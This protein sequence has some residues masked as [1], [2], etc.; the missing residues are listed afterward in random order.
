MKKTAFYICLILLAAAC[1]KETSNE[2]LVDNNNPVNDTAWTS[3]LKTD[4]PVKQLTNLL[5]PAAATATINAATGGSISFGQGVTVTFPANF[6][7]AGI[8]TDVQVSLSYLKSKGDMIRFGRPTTSNNRILISG[9][10][11]NIT[12]TRNGQAAELAP[13]KKF[14]ISYTNVLATPTMGIFFGDTAVNNPGTVFTDSTWV[15]P[16]DTSNGTVTTYE[17]QDSSGLI[18]GYEILSKKFHFINC[19]QFADSSQARGKVSVILPANFTNNNTAVF[20]V[21][22]NQLSVVS[23]YADISNHLF[24]NDRIPSGTAITIVTITKL[25]DNL[26]LGTQEVTVSQNTVTNI[27]PSIKSVADISS[28]L[29]N[30]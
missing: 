1:K 2:F 15:P 4:A 22:K 11:F 24:L 29:D 28:F 7:G 21:F 23:L 8:T 5:S 10:A 25:G 13:D 3:S 19:D 9:G 12:V 6:L 14:S 30:L 18:L 16:A 26:Y 27:T 17:Q 20:A